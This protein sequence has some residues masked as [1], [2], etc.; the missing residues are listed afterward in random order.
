MAESKVN[1]DSFIALQGWMI[2]DLGLKGN[3]LIIYACIYGFTQNVQDQRFTGGRQYLADWTNSTRQG[4]DKCLKSLCE[5]GLIK[6]EE[7]YKNGV[8]YVSYWTTELSG[9]ANKVYRG[10]QQSLQGGG[11]QSC[12]NI[13]PSE[14]IQ[15]NKKDNKPRT[16]RL[17]I[18]GIFARYT[19]DEKTLALLRDWLDVRKAKRAPKTERALTANMDKLATVA[20][21]SGLTI[22]AYL[23]AVIMRGWAAFY[24]IPKYSP[25][26]RPTYGKGA[27]P[28]QQIR[29]GDY[30]NDEMPF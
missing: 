12:H 13:I 20:K 17:D 29:P 27:S 19:K 7:T 11:Q 24:V 8:K 6:R 5:K 28:M 3:E 26:P 10:S 16:A 15:G 4:I 14:N 30:D 22:N 18:D 9:V 1:R 2:T 25:Q 23:E 21:E